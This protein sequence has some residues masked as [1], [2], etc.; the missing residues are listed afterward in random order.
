MKVLFDTNE[1]LDLLLARDEFVD[2][3]AVLI[4]K[5]DT[6]KGSESIK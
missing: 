6:I 5:V 4:S 2:D 3:A 1:I